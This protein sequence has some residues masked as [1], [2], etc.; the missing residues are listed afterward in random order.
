MPELNI[1]NEEV[2]DKPKVDLSSIEEVRLDNKHRYIKYFDLNKNK[3]VML[4]MDI[5]NNSTKEIIEGIQ[6]GSISF[7][8]SDA[9]NNT[10]GILEMEAKRTRVNLTIIPISQIETI[11]LETLNKEQLDFI[12]IIVKNKDT[13]IPRLKF[14]NLEELLVIDENNLVKQCVRDQVT[15]ELTF[16]SADVVKYEQNQKLETNMVTGSFDDIDFEAEVSLIVESYEPVLIKGYQFDKQ[17]MEYYAKNPSLIEQSSME[18][19]QKTIWRKLIEF[20]KKRKENPPKVRKLTYDKKAG[21]AT[22]RLTFSLSVCGIL[23]ILLGVLIL[24]LK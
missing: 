16:K 18:E 20:Y 8:S 15:N 17:A 19:K 14:I 5:G 7:N 6:K 23:L 10:M 4:R 21:F 3:P 2:N 9:L 24:I 11:P 13:Y 12:K 1:K 22:E